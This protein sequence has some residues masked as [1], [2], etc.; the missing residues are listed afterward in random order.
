VKILRGVGRA[1]ARFKRSLA[2]A[3]TTGSAR[4]DRGGAAIGRI[5]DAMRRQ[6][7]AEELPE[8]G[9]EGILPGDDHT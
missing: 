1:F 6:F 9:P 4:A 5:E 3:E 2:P 8:D 7:P